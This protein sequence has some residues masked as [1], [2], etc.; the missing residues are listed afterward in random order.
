MLPTLSRFLSLILGILG[1]SPDLIG[2]GLILLFL[3]FAQSVR[4]EDWTTTDG[5]VYKDIKVIKSDAASVTILDS[6]GGA[7]IPLANLP[8]D[9][10]KR[11]NYNVVQAGAEIEQQK[12]ADQ[13]YLKSVSLSREQ[14]ASGVQV[15]YDR[16]TNSTAT[17]FGGLNTMGGTVYLGWKN[18]GNK[19][20][21]P[22]GVNILI[23]DAQA[24]TIDVVHALIDG[25]ERTPIQKFDVTDDGTIRF[26]LDYD[27]LISLAT[28]KTIEF[29]AG[30]A[31]VSL[32][33]DQVALLRHFI[34]YVQLLPNPTVNTASDSS[35]NPTVVY[36]FT[37]LAGQAGIKGSTDGTCSVARF[38]APKG[39]AL[40]SSGNLYVADYA[41][42][43]VRKIT[44]TGIVST[45]AGLAGSGGGFD[46]GKG[47]AARFATPQ[48]IA[49]D[50][51]GNVYVADANCVRKITPGGIVK[52]LAGLPGTSGN[53]DGA[54]G[55]ARFSIP[56]GVAV[57][58]NGNVYVVDGAPNN[59]IRKITP[60]GVVST[61]A[62]SAGAIDYKDGA[63]TDAHFE[64]PQGVALDSKGNLYVTDSLGSTI[65][66]ITPDSVVSTFA[67]SPE[68]GGS[69]D[70][71]GSDALFHLPMGVAVDASDNVY[72][73]DNETIRRITP[74][75]VVCTLAGSPG[76]KGS[77]DGSGSSAQFNQPD[78]IAVGANGTIYVAD[79]E[80]NTIRV[81][82]PKH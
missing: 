39:L 59:S 38:W 24:G 65:R 73:T 15:Q 44:P 47:S 74:D 23:K 72:V 3:A 75:G 27:S 80:N 40:D 22:Q 36:S 7:S 55:E 26:A 35:G 76:M 61:L 30:Q 60:A 82:T 71:S 1:R 6:D 18:D 63:G 28:A 14:K 25:E 42:A 31:E 32:S 37:T 68:K 52:T 8:P 16:F 62:G 49:V 12:E 45:L 10:Q 34:A 77:A 17:L 5:K 48:G 20:V 69:S 2:I 66:K 78:F 56:M 43:T 21:Q 70:G 58:P 19:S 57:D 46:D 67:G 11:F 79:F 54:A 50:S 33:S 13:A 9:L 41:N 64:T 4:A 53:K 29:K 51:S 81:G